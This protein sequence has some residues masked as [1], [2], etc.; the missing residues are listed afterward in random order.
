MFAPDRQARTAISFHC[1]DLF[2]SCPEC[3]VADAPVRGPGCAV[4][5]SHTGNRQC[6][7]FLHWLILSLL[8][9]GIVNLFQRCL[10]LLP[11]GRVA[12]FNRDLLGLLISF[13]YLNARQ[14]ADLALDCVDAM[15]AANVGNEQGGEFT[16]EYV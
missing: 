16:F 6:F 7:L 14:L 5:A 2:E 13:D 15:T 1:S 3:P 8:F 12:P 10:D 4:G 11:C 9:R